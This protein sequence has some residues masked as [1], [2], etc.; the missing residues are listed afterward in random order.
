[1]QGGTADPYLSVKSGLKSASVQAVN[2]ASTEPKTVVIPMNKKVSVA[3]KT[4]TAVVAK[5]FT[6]PKVI[7]RK[8]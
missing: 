1:M 8:W 6:P 4:K 7:A 3:P 5:T 2:V